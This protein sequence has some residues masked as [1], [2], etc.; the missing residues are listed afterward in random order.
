MFQKLKQQLLKITSPETGFQKK[1]LL[2]VFQLPNGLVESFFVDQ[3]RD[4]VQ[5]LCIT[6]DNADVVLVQQWRPNTEDLELELPGGKIGLGENPLYAGVRELREE[7]GYLGD[8]TYMGSVAYSPYSSGKR[9]Q[10]L[11]INAEKVDENPKLDPNEFVTVLKISLRDFRQK[12]SKFEIRG[13]ELGYVG[14]DYIG[15]L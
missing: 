2:K 14:L 5:V 11:V 3:D 6:K 9:H 15:K 10:V 13:Y 1:T 4:S 12:L 7:T 8:A